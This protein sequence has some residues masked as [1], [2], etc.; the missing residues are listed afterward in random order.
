MA[1]ECEQALFEFGQRREM[2]RGEDFSLNNGEKDLNLVE[3]TGVDGS[4]D[5]DGVGPLGAEAFGSFPAP[6]GR[7]VVHDP[8][9]AVGGL[10]GLLTHNFSDEALHRSD[11]VL[12]LAATEDFSAMDVPSRQVS[13]SAFTKILVL[14]SEGAVG[15]GR[16]TRLFPASGLNARLFIGREHEVVRAQWNPFPNALV[17]IEDGAGFGSKV[18]IAR[19]DPASMLPRAEGI[20]AEPSPQG[21]TADLRDQTLSHHLLTDLLDRE[22]GQGKSEAVRKFTGKRLNLNDE[23]G[24]KSGLYARLEAVPPGQAVER[25]KIACATC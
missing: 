13:P 24:G 21:G 19:E 9:D 17:Q 18:G 10:V 4:V 15:S 5:E 22:A 1:L 20:A 8:K 6:M 11:A 14:D 7:A 23:A 3:P 12:D 25:D 2:V 16:Q